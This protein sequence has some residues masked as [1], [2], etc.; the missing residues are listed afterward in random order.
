LYRA[1]ENDYNRLILYLIITPTKIE[2]DLR[3]KERKGSKII[4]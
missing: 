1:K 2:V 4:K 3:K